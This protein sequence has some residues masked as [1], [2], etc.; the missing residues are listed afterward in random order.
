MDTV[1]NFSKFNNNLRM[2]ND[3]VDTIKMRFERI[4]KRINIEYRGID[5]GKLYGMYV[6]SYGRGTEIWTSDI[7]II[8]QLPYKIYVQYNNYIGNGQSALIQNVKNTLQKTYPNSH[9]RGD[10]QVV[11]INFGDSITFEIVPAFINKDGK[12]FTYPDTNNGGSWKVTKPILEIESMNIRNDFTN[13]NLKKLCRMMRAWKSENNVPISGMLIDTL[14]YHFLTNY[15]YSSKSYVYFDRISR[16]FFKYLKELDINKEYWYAPGSHEKVYKSKDFHY[17]AT[18][19]YN[20]SLEAISC[21]G[22]SH[23]ISAN[24]KW[25]EIYGKKFSI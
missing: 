19:A 23:W 2:D 21:Q 20:R 11:V 17:K 14:V 8:V 1:Q 15:E 9:I 16:D 22:R 25:R 12:S 6:G 4:L 24:L 10:G 18:S 7:D 5:S 13:K 3:V